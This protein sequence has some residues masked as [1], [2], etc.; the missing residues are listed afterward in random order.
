[1]IKFKLC[2]LIAGFAQG[3]AQKQCILLMNEL[4]K[5]P[6]IDLHLIY[7]YEDVNFPDLVQDN[8]HMH[9]VE[10]TS[11]Y[12]PRNIKLIGNLL[13][14]V[15]P[16]VAFS[17]LQAFD[18][19]MFFAKKYV[20]ACKWVVAERDSFYPF[21]LR[22]Y[23]RRKLCVHADL[24]ICNSEQGKLYWKNYNVSD[25]KLAVVSNILSIK[26]GESID[27]VK[28]QP[29]VVYAGR[30]E[31]QKNVLNVLKSF[32][33]LA[34]IYSQGKF[35][36][37]GNGSLQSA[38]ESILEESDHKESI[39][40][41]PFKKNIADYFETADVFV[42]VSLHEGMPNTVIEN[43]SKNNI[44]VVSN[45]DEHKSL[46]GESYPFYVNNLENITEIV[47]V[48]SMAIKEDDA[49]KLFKYAQNK[50]LEMTSDNV[51]TNYVKLLKQV[52]N[53]K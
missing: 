46:L 47:D 28:G 24:I 53:V 13:K 8:I 2:F 6:E 48:I 27:N 44:V 34:D 50:L 14:E 20:P 16:D 33:K 9:Q 37:I 43:V 41:L 35:L 23:L 22:F 18:V 10:I 19:Y 15:K 17:W 52:A 31:V 11:A 36:L 38:L 51:T 32:I 1:V 25:A 30:F 45:I 40:I 26:N 21:D 42:N 4:Q 3:G 29:T 5:H 39:K 12:D 49:N 7:A